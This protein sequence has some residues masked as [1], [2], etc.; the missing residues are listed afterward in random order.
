MQAVFSGP[1][2]SKE[3]FEKFVKWFS[4]Y[5][6]SLK[7]QL[8]PRDFM[9]Y[10]EK[11]WLSTREE[12]IS[13]V[14]ASDEFDRSI[15]FRLAACHSASSAAWYRTWRVNDRVTGSDTS[16]SAEDPDTPSP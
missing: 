4:E 3:E 7:C 8:F 6:V 9:W 14:N 5:H 15:S 13:W 1:L 2:S 12:I 10:N 11:D 16:Y